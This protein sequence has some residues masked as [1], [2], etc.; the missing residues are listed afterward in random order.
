MGADGVPREQAELAEMTVSR[1][2]QARPE[3]R[4]APDFTLH[5]PARRCI[6]YRRREGRLLDQRQSRGVDAKR[7]R[8]RVD[9]PFGCRFGPYHSQSRRNHREQRCC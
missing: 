1:F 8:R 3:D 7:G 5:R 6:G 2:V 9:S 4:D